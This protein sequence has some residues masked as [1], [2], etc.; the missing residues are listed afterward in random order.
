MNY[1][2]LVPVSEFDE[3]NAIADKKFC[4]TTPDQFA[5][6]KE[7]VAKVYGETKI[8]I[9]PRG[10]VFAEEGIMLGRVLADF[11]FISKH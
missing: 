3:L 9:S 4:K 11:T 6:V 7:Q 2:E 5:K 8:A 10:G 1:F